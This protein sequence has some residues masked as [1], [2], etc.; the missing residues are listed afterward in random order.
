MLLFFVFIS[1]STNYPAFNSCRFH[2]SCMGMTIEQAKKIDHYMCA[3]C[4][5]ENGAKRLSN[6]YPVSPNSDSKVVSLSLSHDCIDCVLIFCLHIISHSVLRCFYAKPYNKFW[7][8]RNM[9]SELVVLP[10]FPN[11]FIISA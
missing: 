10:A 11:Y 3:D 4:A 7:F 5:K 2:P 8:S 1:I 9:F 6:S